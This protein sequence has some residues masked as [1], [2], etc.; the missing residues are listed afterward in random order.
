MYVTVIRI[1]SA[2]NGRKPKVTVAYPRPFLSLVNAAGGKQPGL[3][4]QLPD[5][6]RPRLLLTGAPHSPLSLCLLLVTPGGCSR[7]KKRR[8]EPLL[9]RDTGW[10]SGASHELLPQ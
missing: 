9:S 4:W 6:Q 7:G 5:C 3:A 10:I 8:R 1:V 2:T